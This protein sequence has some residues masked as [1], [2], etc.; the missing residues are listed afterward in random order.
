MSERTPWRNWFRNEKWLWVPG[1]ILAVIL[2][3]VVKG[4]RKPSEADLPKTE[5]TISVYMH[6]TGET[7]NMPLETY[8]EGVVA[9]EMDPSWPLEALR[10]QAIVA[11]T[12]TIKKM[13]EGGVPKRGTQASTDPNEFQAYNAARVNDRV[14]QAVR[15]TRGQIVLYGGQPINAWFHASSGGVTA[16]AV[17]GLGYNKERTPYVAPKDDVQKEPTQ[18]WYR[19]FSNADV[20]RA[21]TSVGVPIDR[22]ESIEIGRKGP[23]GRTEVLI[24][25]GKEVPA[26]SF[27]VALGASAMRST[28]LDSVS[29]SGDSIAMKGRGYGHGVGMSQWGAFILAQRGSTA[30]DIVNYYFKNVKVEKQWQ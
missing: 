5:P 17:E 24:I 7:Q 3:T 27:R 13:N 26:P 2:A 28:L 11:R 23:S 4:I 8:L 20:A 6:E 14:R 22:V 15:D 10:A 30:E 18:T 19:T 9:A 12:F 25:N 21:C 1:I 29:M 16:S